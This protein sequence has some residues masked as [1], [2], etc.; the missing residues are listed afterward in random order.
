MYKAI[1]HKIIQATQQRSSQYEN[2]TG[3]S[4]Q[5]ICCQAEEHFYYIEK[6]ILIKY[7]K[8]VEKGGK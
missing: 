4:G 5:G 8:N 3:E 2:K 1:K 7:L 6:C